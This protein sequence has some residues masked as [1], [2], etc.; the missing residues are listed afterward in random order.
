MRMDHRPLRFV[1]PKSENEFFFGK[2]LCRTVGIAAHAP[3][4]RVDRR[5]VRSLR[6]HIDHR[7][8]VDEDVRRD[9]EREKILGS[10]NRFPE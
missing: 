6:N 5:G 10:V 2:R 7:S 1:R 8:F 3:N 4:V 9:D